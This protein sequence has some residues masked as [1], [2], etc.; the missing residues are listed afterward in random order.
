MTVLSLD[1]V[2][3]RLGF[4]PGT[5]NQQTN[6]L[7]VFYIITRFYSIEILFS[8]CDASL[9]QQKEIQHI[10]IADLGSIYINTHVYCILIPM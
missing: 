10:F 5:I 3:P 2:M 1:G 8:M 7:T 4:E 9:P 6:A